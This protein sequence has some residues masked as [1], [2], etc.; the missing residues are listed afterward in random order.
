M[1]PKKQTTEEE[2]SLSDLMKLIKSQG[3]QLT[4]INEK[5]SKVDKIEDEVRDLKTLI[6]SLRDENKML[7]SELKEKDKQIEDMQATINNL[8]LRHNNL[9][10]HHRGW[11]ARV[12]NVPVSE[13]EEA[14]PI[15]M[16]KKVYDL[17]LRPMLE[18][19]VQAGKLEV[20]P[21][22]EQV[23]EV[24]HVLPGK[25]GAPK[26]IIMRFFSRNVR[27]LC[28]QFKKEHATREPPGGDR[29]QGSEQSRG[30]YMYPLYEDLTKVNL[31][32]MRA[33]GQDSRVQACW[34]VNGQIRFRLKDSNTVRKVISVLDPLEEILR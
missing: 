29:R 17:A 20:L 26:P 22:A 5:V 4:S 6:V 23:L 3:E 34:S 2:V 7:R 21:S 28:F 25:K 31:D 9:E 32:K 10:Q 11:G 30:R 13:E 18:G 1:P 24:A 27:N 33:I 19:A 8:D 16:I 15:I 12:L 14:D